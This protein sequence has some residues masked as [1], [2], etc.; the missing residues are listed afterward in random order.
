VIAIRTRRT[1]AFDHIP[2][3]LPNRLDLVEE[4]PRA[5]WRVARDTPYRTH[6]TNILPAAADSNP[7]KE[8]LIAIPTS[9]SA[10]RGLLLGFDCALKYTIDADARVRQP[11]NVSA[12]LTVSQETAVPLGL[13]P[14]EPR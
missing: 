10:A 6:C 8:I 13:C 11:R 14:K 1:D 2:E 9:A 3:P 4:R 5:S 12:F 7:P